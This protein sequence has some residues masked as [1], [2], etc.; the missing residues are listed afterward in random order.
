MSN[1]I[2]MVLITIFTV[3]ACLSI[4]YITTDEVRSCKTCKYCIPNYEWD[5]YYCVRYVRLG[6]AVPPD[7]FGRDCEEYERIT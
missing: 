4:Y 2:F 6:V 1:I 7:T 3:L 5:I